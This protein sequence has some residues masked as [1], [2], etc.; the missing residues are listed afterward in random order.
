MAFG[1]PSSSAN[2]LLVQSTLFLLIAGMAG[3]TDMN[4]LIAQL[5]NLRG[6]ATGFG[7]QFVLLPL[8]GFISVMVFSLDPLYGIML[9][10]TTT[11]PGGGFSGFWCSICNADIALSI[12]MTTVSTFSSIVML[13]ANV[14]LYVTLVYG[15]SVRLDFVGIGIS[16]AVVISAIFTGVLLG[17]YFPSK[18]SLFNRVG[19]F[20]GISNIFLALYSAFVSSGNPT[21]ADPSSTAPSSEND[22]V[23]PEP[24]WFVAV[25]SPCIAGLLISLSI[26]R[27]IKCTKPESVA[28]CIEC[29]FQNTGLANSVAL[30]I[31]SGRDASRALLVPL[32]YGA[33]EVV[34]LSIFGFVAWQIGWTY[35]AR[36]ESMLTCIAA[37]H[38]PEEVDMSDRHQPVWIAS[39]RDKVRRLSHHM[40]GGGEDPSAPV[41]GSSSTVMPAPDMPPMVEESTPADD[42]T[43]TDEQRTNSASESVGTTTARIQSFADSE[44]EPWNESLSSSGIHPAPLPHATGPTARGETAHPVRV[45]PLEVEQR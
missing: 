38:Q 43:K 19:S 13:P 4:G 14:F 29:C 25:A 33:T 9:M 20:G 36:T 5:T 41:A 17:T 18:K 10:I 16:I 24:T 45:V 1:D 6:I 37:N 34:V 30:T 23:V 7:C 27:L 26:A 35:A 44:T 11:S 28:I 2:V 32:F 15:K 21:S 3:T 40:F 31:F 39:V 12:A 8:L 22:F 42:V